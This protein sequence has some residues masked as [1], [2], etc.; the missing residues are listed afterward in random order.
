M[1]ESLGGRV[2]DERDGLSFIR[3]MG[4]G[5]GGGFQKVR[6]KRDMV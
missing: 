6:E 4:R 1:D 3:L 2:G 5:S